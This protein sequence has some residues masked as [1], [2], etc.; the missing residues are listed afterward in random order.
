VDSAAQLAGQALE[1]FPHLKRWYDA[2]EARPAVQ[3]GNA[4]MK[5]ELEKARNAPPNQK[6]WEIMFG[7]KQFEKR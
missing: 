2:I 6:S 3:R 7:T 5:E 4:V 1:D